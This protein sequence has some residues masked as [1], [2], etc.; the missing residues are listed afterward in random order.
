MGVEQSKCFL[1][2]PMIRKM[3]WFS[4]PFQSLP[5]IMAPIECINTPNSESKYMPETFIPCRKHV[6][7]HP[8]TNRI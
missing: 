5:R 4:G 3:D 7:R 8:H 2:G 6:R 1:W